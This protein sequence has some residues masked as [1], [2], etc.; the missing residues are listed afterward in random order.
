MTHTDAAATAMRIAEHGWPVLPCHTPIA[1]RCSCG[2]GDCPSPGKHPRTR[3]GLHDATR[4]P[5]AIRHWWRRW[6][7]ANAAVRTGAAPDGAGIVV[8]DIDPDAG[9][10]RSLEALIADHGP[11]PATLEVHTGGGGRHLYFAH[12]G[13]AIPNSAGRLGAGIDVRGDGGYVL[14]PPSRHRSGGCYR[15]TTL[16][17]PAELPA[18]LLDLVDP[19]RRLPVPSAPAAAPCDR[20]HTAWASA[21]LAGEVASVRGATE[22]CRNHTLNRAAFALGQL[23]AGGHLDEHDVVGALTAAGLAAGLGERE[24]RATIA[25]GLRAGLG[26]PRHPATR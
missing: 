19:D 9:G 20:S 23:V 6:H 2:A 11:L 22:G 26:R 5:D 10:D 7:D 8:V 13:T 15:W 12:P 24:I 17:P 3:R 4:D 14:V 16:G 21:A 18:W 25:S 1:A